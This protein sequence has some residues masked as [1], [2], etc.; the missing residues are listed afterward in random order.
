M[1]YSFHVGDRVV[2]ANPSYVNCWNVGKAGT[3][4]EKTEI[5]GHYP[6]Y[7]VRFDSGEE[8]VL[9]EIELV[10]ETVH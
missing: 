5:P 8:E 2:F 7:R 3:V 4:T 9:Y 10:P 1:R 6:D